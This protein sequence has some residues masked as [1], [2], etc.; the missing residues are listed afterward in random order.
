MSPS[1]MSGRVRGRPGPSRAT[2]RAVSRGVQHRGITGLARSAEDHQRQSVAVDVLMDLHGEATAGAAQRVVSRLD[3][4]IRVIRQFP[5]WRGAGSCRAGGHDRWWSR[6]P[7]TSRA[8]RPHPRGP[9]TSRASRTRSQV[10]SLAQARWRFQTVCQG[11]NSAG[12]SRQAIPH[13]YR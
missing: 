13:R 2:D 5:L 1:S 4:Q 8:C 10:P 12:R 11:P 7:P 3:G 9:G 6:P